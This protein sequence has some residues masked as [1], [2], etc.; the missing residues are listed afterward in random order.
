MSS[1]GGQSYL[2]IPLEC[3]FNF[4][5]DRLKEVIGQH[6]VQGSGFGGQFLGFAGFRLLVADR[7]KG[8]EWN[9]EATTLV[10]VI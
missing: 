9:M 2:W 10:E 1:S 6:R 4:S 8:I 7:E 3:T 5:L